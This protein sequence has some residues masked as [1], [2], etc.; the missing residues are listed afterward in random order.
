[1]SNGRF[2][3]L[4]TLLVAVQ[5]VLTG[6]CNISAT[7]TLSLLSAIV[8]CMPTSWSA[9]VSALAAFAIGIAVDLL[10]EGPIGLNAAALVPVAAVRK[11]IIG[12]FIDKEIVERNYMFS[13]YRYGYFK[14]G[15]SLLLTSIIFFSIFILLDNAGTRDALFCIGRI[16]ISSLCSLPFCMATAGILAPRVRR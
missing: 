5:L 4:T 10:A 7:V 9:P 16:L 14:I 13:Y 3:L 6:L 2:I 12:A 1:M 11:S 8:F 15:G